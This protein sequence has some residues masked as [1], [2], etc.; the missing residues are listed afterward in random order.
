MSI[1]YQ[2]SNF[3]SPAKWLKRILYTTVFVIWSV[4]IITDFDGIT[5]NNTLIIFCIYLFIIIAGQF[6]ELTITQNEIIIQQ[7][8][9]VPFLRSK[10]VVPFNKIQS[11]KKNSNFINNDGHWFA[12]LH[13]KDHNLEVNLFDGSYE[14]IDGK[15][16]SK[17]VVG[18]K[19]LI[20]TKVNL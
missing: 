15:L 19:E 4:Y 3:L 2:T 13:K 5:P 12:F 11:V 18:L 14:L 1:I 8:S 16:Y 9:I 17:G 10:R 20:L 7:K 6:D